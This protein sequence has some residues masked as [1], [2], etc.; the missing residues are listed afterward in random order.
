MS[1]IKYGKF[2]ALIACVPLFFLFHSLLGSRN[3]PKYEKL[4][5]KGIKAENAFV[6]AKEQENHQFIRY[7]YNVNS[8]FYEGIG[9]A[10]NGNPRFSEI[11]NG[12]KVLVFYDPDSPE[13][14]ILGNPQIMFQ[15][16]QD[17]VYFASLI[18]SLFLSI[19]LCI[20]IHS[21]GK[22]AI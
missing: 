10:G 8:E 19:G 14:S 13:I 15:R 1:F 16:E 3:L 22:F 12:D 20:F 6:T 21:L 4:A 9:S 5:A 7:K 2:L 17:T 18:V 11:E